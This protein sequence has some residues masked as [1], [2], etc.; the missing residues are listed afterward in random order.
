MQAG[1]VRVAD[2]DLGVCAD[3]GVELGVGDEGGEELGE[4]GAADGADDGGNG[5]VGE[6]GAQLGEAVRDAG[7]DGGVGCVELADLKAAGGEDGCGACDDGGEFV[8]EAC[9]GRD[10]SDSVA[11]LE[12]L[13]TDG[14]RHGVC[15]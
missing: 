5:G 12:G 4:G 11:G 15:E 1:N 9:G 14:G 6:G 10:Q 8:V 2:D 13:R 3:G 7:L